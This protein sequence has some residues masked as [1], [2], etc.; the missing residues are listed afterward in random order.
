MAGI[1]RH[2]RGRAL[3]SVIVSAWPFFITAWALQLPEVRAAIGTD[4]L[5]TAS[6]ACAAFCA[7]LAFTLLPRFAYE[8]RPEP[9]LLLL[10]VAA[11]AYFFPL[12]LLYGNPY[13]LLIWAGAHSLQYYLLVL[14]SLS[15]PNEHTH[16]LKRS[17]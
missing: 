8:D 12:L 4:T 14:M 10:A 3:R 16:G 5:W 9:R 15:L 6:V 1:A 7:L 2:P 11:C 13:A 17:W